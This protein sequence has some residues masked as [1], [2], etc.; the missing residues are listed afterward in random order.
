MLE[1]NTPLARL[2]R[3]DSEGLLGISLDNLF[4]V[5]TALDNRHPK[6]AILLEIQSVPLLQLLRLITTTSYAQTSSEKSIGSSLRT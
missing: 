1:E 6:F 3:T 2:T 5:I 4:S